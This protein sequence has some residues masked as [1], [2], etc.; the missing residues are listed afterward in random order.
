ML[1]LA[2]ALSLVATFYGFEVKKNIWKQ[3]RFES[4]MH[5]NAFFRQTL[6][7]SY[8]SQDTGWFKVLKKVQAYSKAYVNPELRKERNG[9]TTTIVSTQIEAA[10]SGTVAIEEECSNTSTNLNLK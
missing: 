9:T 7:S 5:E 8:V 4:S 3:I 10:S 1:D 2:L 6:Q